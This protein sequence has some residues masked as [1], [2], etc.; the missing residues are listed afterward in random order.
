VQTNDV[1][2]MIPRRTCGHRSLVPTKPHLEGPYEP[3]DSIPEDHCAG[4]FYV[5]VP[6]L[7]LYLMLGEVFELVVAQATP[8]AD[9]FPPGTFDEVNFPCLWHSF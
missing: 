5:L 7:L 8:I 4:G 6:I 9:L 3:A 2:G 1:Q